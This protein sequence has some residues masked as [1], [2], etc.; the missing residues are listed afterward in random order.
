[1][2]EAKRSSLTRH[3]LLSG[4]I[5]AA[6]GALVA[7]PGQTTVKAP[8]LNGT[9][10]VENYGKLPLAF[11]ANHGQADPSVKFLSRGSGY[12]LFLTGSE[13]VLALGRPDRKAIAE[14][15]VSKP[16]ACGAAQDSVRMKLAGATASHAVTPT[17]EAE[18][19]GKVNYFIGNDPTKWHSDLPTYAKVR[20]RQV[21]PGV[22]LVYYG[23]QR[24]LEYDFIVAP[25]A[26]AK[27]IQLQFS[28]A[29]KLALNADGDLA[30]SATNGAIAFHKPAIYQLKNGHRQPVEGQFSLAAK[31]LVG[32]RIGKYDHS[33][34]LVIDPVLVYSTYLGG[35]N[36]FNSAKSIVVDTLGN[37]YVAGFTAASDFPVSEG[38]FQSTNHAAAA[39]GVSAFV[40]KFNST[41]TA[42]LYS[43]Y[44]GGGASTVTG[45]AIT[46]PFGIAVDSSG[47]AFVA[48]D[49]Y[50]SDFPV[51]SGAFQT[52]NHA[53]A[54][55]RENAF[56]TKLNPTGT[57]LLY[58]TYLGGSGNTLNSAGDDASA[59][60]VDG[61]GDA[62]VTGLAAS[63][64]FPTTPGAFQTTN[65]TN[66]KQ[67]STAFVTKLN[68]DGTALLYSTY[69][70]GTVGDYGAGIAL[71]SSGDAYVT[72]LT[73]STNFPVT[74]GVVQPTLHGYYNAFI[75]KLNSTGTALL[76][77]TFLGGTV[78]D[79]GAAI[80]V[81][82][83]GDIYVTGFAHSPNFPVTSGSFQ[84]A[85]GSVFVTKFNPEATALLY[86]ARFG[87]NGNRINRYQDYSASIALD[88]LGNAYVT[89]QTGSTNFPVT[90]GAIQ[91]VNNAAKNNGASGFVTKLNSD[92][93]T[94]LY[95]T[96]LGGGAG[97]L[98][99]SGNGI[100]VDNLG[101][102][103]VVGSTSATDFPVTPGAYQTLPG[104]NGAS[105][106]VSKL[107]ISRPPSALTA[108]ENGYTGSN[109]YG[110]PKT[111]FMFGVKVKDADSDGI[112]GV[113]VNFT[114]Q[115]LEFLA[116]SA[117]TDLNGDAYISAIPLRAGNLAATASVSG[118]SQQLMLPITVAPAPL[119]VGLRGVVRYYGVAN[120]ALTY[121]VTGLIG[122]D[123]VT[124]VPSTT[125]TTA[126]LV[127]YYPITATVTG[128]DA[129]NYSV[130]VINSV[131]HV[132]PAPLHIVA[133]NV[134]ITYGQTPAQPTAYHLTGFVNGDTTSV[135]SGAPV[136]STSVT[137][138]TP[139]GIYKIGI[140]TG[141]LTAANYFF[142]GVSNGEGSIYVKKAHLALTA[143]NQTMT[144]GG[145]VP[146]LTYTLSGFV[147]GQ[148][149]A[150][151]V[152]GTPLLSTTATSA[153]TP[154]HY[155]ITITPGSLTATNYVFEPVKGIMTVLP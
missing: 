104:A 129:A 40:A 15:R 138:T 49:T 51:T 146:A 24:Q 93:T 17:G 150:G 103:Y 89:G 50:S 139:A 43:T 62:F 123:A 113:S 2:R 111:S 134:A 46:E 101:D 145:T 98:S 132:R 10:S 82:D 47:N 11:E 133:A 75:T 149:A 18:L 42:L 72:G 79:S 37:A 5:L 21:Y 137:S 135:V 48:G 121:T 65:N 131:L 83:S 29:K 67:N 144:Q 27:A 105:A 97:D 114:G 92:G 106:F 30:V 56:V 140:Q 9:K 85:Y 63:H 44:L 28:G 69:L 117:M 6:S 115:G 68:P 32:F 26:D 96:Y 53:A 66:A 148:N 45:Q 112:S 116:S 22:D 88:A 141:T 99:D 3:S 102:A 125:A 107:S 90:A 16:V 143:T 57:A 38:A 60:V 87:G 13:A 136:L 35:S 1:M 34:P 84:I 81:D 126:S 76:Y 23:N 122:S 78:G 39:N 74:P 147:N 41:G 128:T 127:G 71:D 14:G 91:T 130:I 4:V 54:V 55:G 8:A 59:I 80:A 61:L 142:T 64:D 58:S 25:R 36:G 119:T 120:P 95:S 31:N 20:Y 86:S 124:V 155:Y 152:S 100:A 94:L 33:E 118:V 7:V 154:G 153:S 70:G 12:S 151:T 109:V 19:P 77:S 52:V 110:N 73:E 108:I